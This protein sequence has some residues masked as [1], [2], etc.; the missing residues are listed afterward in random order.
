MKVGI[1]I[2]HYR[3]EGGDGA[4]SSTLE[5]IVRSA[6]QAGLDSIWLMD[7]LLQLGAQYGRI[8]G[9]VDDPMLECYTTAGFIA[10]VTERI[11]VGVQVTC[12]TFRSPGLLVKA[13]TTLDVLAS[14][15]A[16]LGLGAGW[17]E[18]EATALGLFLPDTWTERFDRLEETLRIVRHITAGDDRPFVGR[19]HVLAEPIIQPRPL[20]LLPIMIGGGGEKKTLALVARYADASNLVLASPQAGDE[21]GTW[22]NPFGSIAEYWTKTRELVRHKSSVLDGH[23]ARFGRDPGEI[24]RTATTYLDPTTLTQDELRDILGHFSEIGIDHLVVDVPTAYEIE[25][26][27]QLAAASRDE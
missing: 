22:A 15:R 6:E 2:G 4:I 25:P 11:E 1:H 14:G 7:H 16:W 21:F 24:S 27:E 5:S 13:V 20:G 17:Y 18:R 8:H 9:P 23:C 26:L 12:N 3:Y 19:Y 10:A